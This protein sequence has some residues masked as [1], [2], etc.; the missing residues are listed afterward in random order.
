MEKID[1]FCLIGEFELARE[2]SV[3]L[4]IFNIH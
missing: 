4:V 2:M 3:L 1:T